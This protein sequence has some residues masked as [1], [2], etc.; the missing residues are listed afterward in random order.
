MHTPDQDGS[1]TPGGGGGYNPPM[2][3]AV[4][5][6]APTQLLERSMES[7][8]CPKC[9]RLMDTGRVAVSDPLGYVSDKQTGM[10]RRA[11]SVNVGLA[12]TNC[13]YVELY[14]DPEELKSRLK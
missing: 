7:H 3:A 4:A 13:G 2:P 6:A 5:D 9:K 8:P 10:V 1:V 11:T 14:L 12:C